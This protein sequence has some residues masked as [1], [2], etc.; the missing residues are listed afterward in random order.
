MKDYATSNNLISQLEKIIGLTY[1]GVIQDNINKITG[2][3][4]YDNVNK[5]YYE[6]I[7]DN[8]LKYTDNSKFRAISNKPINDSIGELSY[9]QQTE[10]YVHSEAIGQASSHCNVVYKLGRLVI[11]IFDSGNTLYNVS[12]DHI[13]FSLPE[14]FRPK[15]LISIPSATYDGTTGLI[16]IQPD[17]LAKW[18]AG[19]VGTR[20][21]IFTVSFII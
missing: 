15:Q 2:K 17:G 4:Y 8:N 7:S 13:I 20:N 5:Y 14:G 16:Y 21:I 6:C 19:N 12:F 11:I 1:G 9:F 18:K 3:F 10:L